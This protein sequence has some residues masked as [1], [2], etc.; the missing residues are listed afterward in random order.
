M[1]LPWLTSGF[2]G[3]GGTIKQRPED[4]FVQE[5]PLYEPSG[6]G[7][8]VLFEAQK[9]GLTTFEAVRRLAQALHVPPGDIGYA[10][11]KDAHAITRQVFSIRGSSEEAVMTTPVPGLQVL[12][13]ARHGNK[14]RL[15]HLAGNRFAI[16]IREVNPA[17]VVKL[18]PVIDL[19]QQR[20]M[21]NYFGQQRFGRRGDNHRLG[22]ALLRADDA[23]LLAQLLGR[24]D[25][26]VDDQPAIEARAAFDAADYQT[27]IR[28]W[29][30][31]AR[32][33]RAV[34]AR[35]MRT[36]NPSAA[37]RAVDRKLR[38]LWISALQSDLFNHVLAGRIAG[39]DQ[40]LPGDLA[41][42]HDSGA[43]FLVEDAS[44]EQ[45]RCDAFAV[46]P[47]GPLIGYRM[48]LP[49][50]PPLHIEQEV[51][52]QAGLMPEDFWESGR[53]NVRGARRPLRVQPAEVQ[54]AAGV[55]EHG[56]HITVAFTLPAGSFATVLLDELMKPQ[57]PV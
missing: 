18:R 44:A 24:P 17:D 13:A 15:G 35:L 49:Q 53:L 14:L 31:H 11:M 45:P 27:A 16:K 32:L 20:G 8:H 56:S 47:S 48:T 37:V 39:I 23:E 41:W 25:P 43:V 4:F 22:A 54:L 46:S 6:Q 28:R 30:H 12:W 34:L 19:L 2:P 9:V 36:G 7:E 10:G 42:K 57:Q 50:G 55:D 51:M 52:S 3:I 38:R 40:L 26:A 29:P 5:L 1:S 33:E 21:P